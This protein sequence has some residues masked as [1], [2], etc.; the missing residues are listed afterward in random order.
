MY[1]LVRD[2]WPKLAK[3]ADIALNYAAIQTED[4]YVAFLKQKLVDEMNA[5]LAKEDIDIEK[6]VDIEVILKSVIK[7]AKVSEEDF[8]E[9]Y[10]ESVETFGGFDN[11]Y[12]VFYA[13][14]ATNED[15]AA[16]P[17]KEK[18]V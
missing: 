4:L 17:T 9:K 7:A 6:L 11:K 8:A 16:Q 5:F 14:Q 12:I 2:N 18:E 3:D 15:T 13:D 10:A 1:T